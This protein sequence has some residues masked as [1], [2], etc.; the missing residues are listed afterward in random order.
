MAWAVAVVLVMALTLNGSDSTLSATNVSCLIVNLEYINCTW[1]EGGIPEFNYTF[2]SRFG[3]RGS[4]MECPMY[5]LEQ[6]LSVGCRMPY[7]KGEKFKTLHTRLSWNN[8]HSAREQDIYMKDLVKLDPPHSLQVQVKAD[9]HHPVLLLSWNFS[10]PSQCVESSVRY[11]RGGG[12]WRTTEPRT[13]QSF[14]LSFFSED[15]PYEFQVRTRV[16]YVCG[17]SRFWSGW[18][19]PFFWGPPQVSK[20]LGPAQYGHNHCTGS[21][22]QQL[23]VVTLLGIGWL[24]Q[25]LEL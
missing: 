19:A 3:H 13:G 4:Y 14:S 25:V 23:T 1:T 12:H 18:S 16:P 9:G 17:Q 15:L 11:K 6:G 22:P 21:C 20:R 7:Q 24:W 5:L 8:S 2:H 10:T